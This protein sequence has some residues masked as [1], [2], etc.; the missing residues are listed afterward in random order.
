MT[1]T[2][3]FFGF[4]FKADIETFNDPP[5]T[6]VLCTRC[7][8]DNDGLPKIVQKFHSASAP[9]ILD[10]LMGHIAQYHSGAPESPVTLRAV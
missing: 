5:V 10:R 1:V 9:G 2:D 7:E 4:V 6:S 8:P 3:T